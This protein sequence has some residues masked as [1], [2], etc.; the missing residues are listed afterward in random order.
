MTRSVCTP[1]AGWDA[2]PSHRYPSIKFACT[3]LQSTVFIAQTPSGHRFK[4]EI[5]KS[6]MA[7]EDNT[8]PWPGHKP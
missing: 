5:A 8:V 3:H 6:V 2:S 4:S 1:P 7:K